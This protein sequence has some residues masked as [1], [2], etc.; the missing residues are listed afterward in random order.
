MAEA[1]RTE[2]IQ[3]F[4]SN[5]K[6][7]WVV[8]NR[9]GGWIYGPYVNHAHYAGLMELLVPFPLILS[10]INRTGTSGR[11]FFFFAVIALCDGDT[12]DD[13]CS[14]VSFAVYEDVSFV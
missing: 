11:A 14:F 13:L 2:R 9:Y 6:I 10:I 7:Y 12:D 3:Q 8:T 4:T 5:G 1:A